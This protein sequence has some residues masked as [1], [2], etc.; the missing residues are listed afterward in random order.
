MMDSDLS[1]GRDEGV[2]SKGIHVEDETQSLN[3]RLMY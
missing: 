3:L 1:S 2:A